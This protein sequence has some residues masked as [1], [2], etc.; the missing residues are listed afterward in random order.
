M[1]LNSF[2]LEM[3]FSAIYLKDKKEIFMLHTLKS[4]KRFSILLHTQKA[5]IA[6]FTLLNVSEDGNGRIAVSA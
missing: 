4:K 2:R 6:V 5:K 3:E 1:L